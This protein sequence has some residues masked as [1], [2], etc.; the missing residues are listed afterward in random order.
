MGRETS[1]KPPYEILAYITLEKSRFLGGNP[2]CLLAKDE[3]EQKTLTLD[4]AKA[5]KADVTQLNSGDYVVLR[6]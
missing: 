2:L 5:L 1:M 3:E 4:L 6:V